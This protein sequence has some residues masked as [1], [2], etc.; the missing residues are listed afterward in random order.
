MKTNRIAA[1]VGGALLAALVAVPSMCGA[2]APEPGAKVKVRWGGG[3]TD[4]VVV[5]TV[6]QNGWIKVRLRVPGGQTI[7]PVLPPDKVFADGASA[8]AFEASKKRSQAELLELN[9]DGKN[10]STTE[11]IAWHKPGKAGA[12]LGPEIGRYRVAAYRA[13]SED[14]IL[15]APDGKRITINICDIANAERGRLFDLLKQARKQ[16]DPRPRSPARVP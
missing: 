1:S 8:A 10:V 12:K 2:G 14:V 3:I 11:F 16:P 13:G 5:E 6:P 4:A 7:E 9:S 15:E